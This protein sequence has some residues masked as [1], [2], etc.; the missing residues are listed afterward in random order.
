[1]TTAA[2]V[3]RIAA[4]IEN[5]GSG[6]SPL[7]IRLLGTCEMR[8]NGQPLP[9]LPSRKEQWLL[10]LL[11]LRHARDTDRDWLAATLWPDA[12][13][14]R[15]RFYLRR[16]L[17]HLRRALGEQESRLLSPTPR[18]LRLDLSGGGAWS[19]VLAFDKALK[20]NDEERAVGLYA[21]P[22]L[23][24][25][26][27]EWALPERE[28]RHQAYLAAL[29]TLAEAAMVRG[30]PAAATR[31]LR[32]AVVAD[33]Y[34][35][36]AA[37]ALMKALAHGG[38]RAAATQVY[39]DLRVRLHDDLNADPAPETQ[40][41]FRRLTAPDA[42]AAARPVAPP[43]PALS[44]SAARRHLPVPLTDLIGRQ[45]ALGEVAGRLRRARL[46]TLVGPG[47]VGKTRLAIGAAEA[48]L[49]HFEGGVWFVDL[50]P[51]TGGALVPD[52][53]A[54]ALGL[55]KPARHGAP[56]ARLVNALAARTLLL[57][58]DNCEH[59]LPACAALAH[60]LLS[61][62]PGLRILAT[63]REPLGVTGEQAFPV[64]SLA[65]PP[66]TVAGP[67]ADPMLA[68]K[69]PAALMVYGAVRLFVERATQAAPAFRLSRSN[70]HAVAQI[71]CRLDG[72][73][74][75]L[76]MAAARVRSLSAPEIEARLRD[77]FRLL[78]TGNRAAAPRQQSLRAAMD[79]SW[80]LLTN[81]EKTLLRRLSVFAGG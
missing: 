12:E 49:P 72:I 57:V 51:L 68:E 13:E 4:R 62:C 64:T 15:A 80:D 44:P 47:G 37:C 23:P 58:L 8:P 78:T 79:W 36:S 14:S 26:A 54:A 52:A 75:A 46:V 73:P 18:T 45:E 5:S 76:E 48:A 2:P 39:R 53:V 41:L 10:A 71:C 74:L 66:E 29:E 31:W 17:S 25:C 69:D 20:E 60:A 22:L 32:L 27:E 81:D 77:R 21:G 65:L 61:A 38:D 9:S 56:E 40:H 67:K 43:P 42:P 59:V 30:E 16:S 70:V 7:E 28:A 24:D 1:M 33:P 19:D 3:E 35:E 6:V 34:R 55:E 63:S 50:A 11:V